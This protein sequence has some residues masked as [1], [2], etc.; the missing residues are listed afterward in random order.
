MLNISSA[1]RGLKVSQRADNQLVQ[2]VNSNKQQ[3]IITCLLFLIAVSSQHKGVFSVWLP[4]KNLFQV[5]T[6][7]ASL[8]QRTEEGQDLV[9]GSCTA[10]SNCSSGEEGGPSL[11]ARGVQ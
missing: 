2:L 5:K 7:A 1:G 9:P 11:P 8:N 6:R 10:T 3:Q 4:L